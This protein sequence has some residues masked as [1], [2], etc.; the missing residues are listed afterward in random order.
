MRCLRLVRLVRLVRFFSYLGRVPSQGLLGRAGFQAV[1][2]V[3]GNLTKLTT[4][5]PSTGGGN[6]NVA[7]AT[8]TVG[9]RRGAWAQPSPAQP[10]PAQPVTAHGVSRH[11]RPLRLGWGLPA[12]CQ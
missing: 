6:A 12:E 11:T 8:S 3:E 9:V 1:G 2:W 5:H 10:S 4:D 7:M